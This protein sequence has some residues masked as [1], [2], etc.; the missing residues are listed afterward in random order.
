MYFWTCFYSSI[1]LLWIIGK[2]HVKYADVSLYAALVIVWFVGAFRFNIGTD[3]ST[4]QLWYDTWTSYK[5]GTFDLGEVEPSF[6]FINMFFNSLGLKSQ[7]LF[8]IFE[9]I[10]I[11]FLYKGLRFYLRDDLM[12]LLGV[13]LFTFY[14]TNGGHWWDMNGIRQGA[15]VSIA[16]WSTKFLCIGNKKKFVCAVLLA[17]SFHY[18]AFLI[19]L[20]CGFYKKR[21][22]NKIAFILILLGFLSNALGV[23]GGLAMQLLAFMADFIGKYEVA[24]LQGTVGAAQFSVMAFLLA[25]L[26]FC[27]S[28]MNDLPNSTKQIL[29]L[30]GAVIYVIFRVYM[31]FG[32]EG[33]LMSTVVHRFETYFLFLY[34]VLIVEALRSFMNKQKNKV[35]SNIFV[36]FFLLC[37]MAMGLKTIFEAGTDVDSQIIGTIS[38]GNIDYTV[39]FD[40]FD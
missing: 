24:V 5:G 37:F 34:L 10:T 25:F 35:L 23:T 1:L 3:Y 12:I 17:M 11:Y 27:A 39:N 32:I 28:K 14:P 15:A 19:L 8:I 36:L 29:V 13:L 31:S 4:Y 16:F 18:S 22:N 38:Q 26:Y 2:C 9:T 21:I 20:L 30:N 40:L 33:S 6:F 7:M